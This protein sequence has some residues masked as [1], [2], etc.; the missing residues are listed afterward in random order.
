[1]KKR[2]VFLD[3]YR[4]IGILFMIMGHVGFGG[5][6]YK[7]I[8][9]FNMPMF[10]FLTGYFFR[11]NDDIPNILLKKIKKL[12][13]PY[14][15]V[16][17]IFCFVGYI[18]QLGK[19]LIDNFTN[20]IICDTNNMIIG[21]AIWYL[22]SMFF[23]ELIYNFINLLLKNEMFKFFTCLIIVVIGLIFSNLDIFIYFSI[24]PALVGVGFIYL[25][26]QFKK[27]SELL[28]D[29]I[30]E[31]DPQKFLFI[32]FFITFLNTLLIFLNEEVNMRINQ[33]GFIP[34]FWINSITSIL[35]IFCVSYFLNN[36]ITKSYTKIKKYYYNFLEIGRNSI[37]YLCFNQ[38][39]I[40]LLNYFSIRMIVAPKII[41]KIIIL[42]MTLIILNI[43]NKII[44]KSKF[45]ILFGL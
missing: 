20:F 18:F 23:A 3:F 30:D 8:H 27:Y 43:L 17:L 42:V 6:F 36:F 45:R 7:F 32:I 11:P 1:M 13:L 2:V 44:S 10:F 34:L 24:V 9:A 39:I 41:L 37:I 28:I 4:T 12:L 35:L 19:G 21:A 33:Y 29:K 40:F 5:V 15:T 25:G 22:L 38:L 31:F 14:L 16:T 26:D